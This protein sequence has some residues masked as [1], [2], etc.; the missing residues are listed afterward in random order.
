MPRFDRY[1]DERHYEVFTVGAFARH[2][3]AQED[4]YNRYYKHQY[5]YKLV[6][7]SNFTPEL[8]AESTFLIH[9]IFRGQLNI[10][11]CRVRSS[12]PRLI[13]SDSVTVTT[14]LGLLHLTNETHATLAP[15]VDTNV[16]VNS[17]YDQFKR[18]ILTANEKTLT[19][20]VVRT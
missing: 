12:T 8:P 19:I 10:G 9:L 17:G 2:A 16:T 6:L 7:I 14:D 11:A 1:L 20:K 5:I 3:T 13:G 4:L 15:E 18:K